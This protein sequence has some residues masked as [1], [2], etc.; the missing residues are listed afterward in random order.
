MNATPVPIDFRVTW[1]F[2]TLKT[3]ETC[4]LKYYHEK[5]VK[6]VK[7]TPN[8]AAEYGTQAHKALEELAKSDTPLPSN[9]SQYGK[10]GDTILRLRDVSIMSKFEY[11]M[12]VDRTY[13]PVP[14]Y[15]DTAYGRA[16]ADVYLQTEP[17]KVVIIDYK[18][19]KYRGSGAQPV[20]NAWITMKNHPEI[21][22]VTTSFVY[23]KDNYQDRAEFD[24]G[25]IDYKFGY[26]QSLIDQLEYAVKHQAFPAKRNGLCRNYCD[27]T[28]CFHC[29]RK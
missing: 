11:Q 2:S 24:R 18:F 26:V 16:V 4:P 21:D 27:V 29:G 3:F 7:Q 25:S 17:D 1:S 14:F 10:L 5:V 12:A 8:V 19:G 23:V 9:M 28:S 6:S 15:N 22:R 20:I 13:A